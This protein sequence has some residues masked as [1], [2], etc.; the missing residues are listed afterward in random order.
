MRKRNETTHVS[1]WYTRRW[2]MFF[3]RLTA[4]PGGEEAAASLRHE[5][6]HRDRR[7]RQRDGGAGRHGVGDDPTEIGRCV[8][9]AVRLRGRREALHV[10]RDA[11]GVLRVAVDQHH[12]ERARRGIEG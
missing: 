11:D 2:A 4:P 12:P 5:L 9:V 8:H 6:E 3:L 7:R 1:T 10:E